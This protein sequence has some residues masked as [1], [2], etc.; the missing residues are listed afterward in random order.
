M[1]FSNS[2][3]FQDLQRL[4]I[5]PVIKQ[6]TNLLTQFIQDSKRNLYQILILYKKVKGLI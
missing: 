5:K 1:Y 4:D 2:I 6:I 3:R